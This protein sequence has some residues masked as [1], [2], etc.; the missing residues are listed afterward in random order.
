MRGAV[1][2]LHAA[3]ASSEEAKARFRREGYIAN[4]IAHPGVVRVVDDDVDEDGNLFVVMEL[5]EGATLQECADS[6][7]GRLAVDE[8]L[9]LADQALDALGAAHRM[10][11]VHRDVKPENVF[12]TTEGAVKILDFGIAG[13]RET[14]S[15]HR[16]VTV[17]GMLMGSP[18]YMPPEQARGRW[19]LVDARSDLWSLGATMFTLLTGR[20]P[21]SEETI[22]ELLA[23]AILTPVP[24][25]AEVMPEAPAALVALVDRALRMD[26]SERWPDADAMRAAVGEV[27]RGLP[28][29]ESAAV[30]GPG[31]VSA[32][33]STTVVEE[34]A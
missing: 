23:A 24:S 4:K 32:I 31:E 21:R 27:R 15:M 10:G 2:V 20:P 30:P 17:A 18:S 22:P 25:L 1:K 3:A 8:V 16:P 26:P 7:G 33:G 6:A 28:D 11:V 14:P 19:E 9:L 34:C 5:L 12:L 13:I 29:E